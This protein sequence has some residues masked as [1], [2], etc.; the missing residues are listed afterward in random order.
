VNWNRNY[1]RYISCQQLKEPT[2]IRHHK[3]QTKGSLNHMTIMTFDGKANNKVFP[4]T[5]L[6]SQRTENIQPQERK[7]LWLTEVSHPNQYIT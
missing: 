4:P 3:N 1:N 5:Q 2:E 7:Y 6:E